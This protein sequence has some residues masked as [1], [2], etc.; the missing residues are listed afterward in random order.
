[1]KVTINIRK[2]HLAIAIVAIALIAPTTA[3]AVHVF[4]DVPD[5]A[6][7]SEPVEWAFDNG[8]TTGKSPT[9]FDPLSGVTRGESVTFAKRYDDNIVQP[10]LAALADDLATLSQNVKSMSLDPAGF[11]TDGGAT[12]E[13]S[14]GTQNTGLVFP[15]GV[16][17][18]LTFT[19]VLPTD[20]TP[21]SQVRIE[22]FWHIKETGCS[23]DLTQNFLSATR[24]GE[25]GLYAPT[26]PVTFLS[27]GAP[28]VGEVRRFAVESIRDEGFLPGDIMKY[29][30]FR[31][32]DD[33]TCTEDVFIDGARILYD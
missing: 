3:M 4:D 8:I 9:S 25:I 10:A 31:S 7:Y 17:P 11:F 28:E 19:A 26:V 22:I 12:F 32:I 15:D 30:L 1:M 18:N 6:F 14:G 24:L 2:V 29:G 27:S 16:L 33:D 23:V 20:F 5:D 13:I 21:G